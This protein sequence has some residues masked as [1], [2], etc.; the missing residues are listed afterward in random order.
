[1]SQ[2]RDCVATSKKFREGALGLSHPA[3]FSALHAGALWV[4]GEQKPWWPLEPIIRRLAPSAHGL[5]R[6]LA[7]RIGVLPSPGDGGV[8]KDA[9][10]NCRTPPAGA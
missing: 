2:V 7:N 3:Q 4:A 10:M 9:C 1:M 6:S 5:D 8:S